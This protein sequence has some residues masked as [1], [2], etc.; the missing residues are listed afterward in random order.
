M[1]TVKILILAEPTFQSLEHTDF[2]LAWT[3][4]TVEHTDFLPFEDL[5]VGLAKVCVFS[6]VVKNG[7]VTM[8][9]HTQSIHRR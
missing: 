9:I 4:Q 6:P 7:I 2:L 5:L 8:H 1:Q 3:W